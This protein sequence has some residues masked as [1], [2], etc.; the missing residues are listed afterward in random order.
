M[1]S[2]ETT[3][4]Y[5]YKSTVCIQQCM[6]QCNSEYGTQNKLEKDVLDEGMENNVH[7]IHLLILLATCH[8]RKH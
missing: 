8:L 6:V 5:M 4:K 7:L 1:Q 2:Q 3:G